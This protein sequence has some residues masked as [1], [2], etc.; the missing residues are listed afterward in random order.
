VN[1]VAVLCLNDYPHSVSRAFP[2]QAQ[3][4]EAGEEMKLAAQREHEMRCRL[5]RDRLDHPAYFHRHILPQDQRSG[6]ERRK[7]WRTAVACAHDGPNSRRGQ[8]RK[9]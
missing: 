4:V 9:P 6:S 1:Y 3:A 5:G 2:T 8:R 7:D